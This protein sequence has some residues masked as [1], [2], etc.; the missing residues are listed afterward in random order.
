MSSCAYAVFGGEFLKL[1]YGWATLVN[2]VMVNWVNI[3]PPLESHIDQPRIAK[4]MSL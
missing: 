2:Y 1:G 4:N 3:F